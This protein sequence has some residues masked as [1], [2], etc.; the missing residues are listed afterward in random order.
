MSEPIKCNPQIKALNLGANVIIHITFLFSILG[1]L[2]MFYISKLTEGH[3]STELNRVIRQHILDHFIEL[4]EHDKIKTRAMIKALPI[5]KLIKR[6]S[7][8]EKARTFN[9]KWL[10]TVITT[11]MIM[12]AFV[13]LLLVVYSK[14]MC[15]DIEIGHLLIENLIIFAGIAVVEGAFFKFII[16]NYV[17][18]PP[19]YIDKII[20][21]YNDEINKK[22][23]L[24][25]EQQQNNT[26]SNT[27]NNTSNNT[28]E[29]TNNKSNK[30]LRDTISNIAQK[31]STKEVIGSIIKKI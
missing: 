20:S 26:A 10:R 1:L 31:Q 9:N 7:E 23:K 2:F 29:D 5:D 14:M 11:V 18:A 28:S 25:K 13:V 27:S 30:S 22:K 3:I 8:S 19:S 17:P 21:E 16:L 6:Y 24:E 4:S 15:V 12:L